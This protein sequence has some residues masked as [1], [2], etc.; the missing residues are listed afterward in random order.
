MAE[1]K[2][3]SGDVDTKVPSTAADSELKKEKKKKKQGVFSR[4]WNAVFRSQGDDFEKRLQHITK[5]E[6]SV[7][8]RMRRRSQSWKR[9]IRNFII[10]SVLVEVIMLYN[11]L[12]RYIS[13]WK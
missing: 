12:W 10:L 6:A 11:F 2:K 1:S 3:E 4:V 8:S 9:M 7:L 13:F 5:E